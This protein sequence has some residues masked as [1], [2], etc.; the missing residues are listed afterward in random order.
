MLA[1]YGVVNMGGFHKLV[2]VRAHALQQLHSLRIQRAMTDVDRTAQQGA[3]LVLRERQARFGGFV[4][5]GATLVMSAAG[6]GQEARTPSV[7]FVC[8]I[9]HNSNPFFTRIRPRRRKGMQRG[10]AQRLP[11]PSGKWGGKIFDFVATFSYL[12]TLLFVALRYAISNL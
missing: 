12:A 6:A 11:L 3:A 8:I 1:V 2:D 10:I 5:D 4:L 9:S 7:I